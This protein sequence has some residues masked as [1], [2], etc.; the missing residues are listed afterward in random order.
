MVNPLGPGGG[1][2]LGEVP[3]EWQSTTQFEEE[4]PVTVNAPLSPNA[5]LVG[6]SPL[7]GEAI[8]G[9]LL[10]LEMGWQNTES[11]LQLGDVWENYVMVEWRTGTGERLAEQLDPLPLPIE[12]WGRGAVLRSRHDVIVPPILESGRY[13]LWAMLH[14]S[15]DP[16]GEAIKLA[17]IN[18]TAP[19]HNF[20]LPAEAML[21]VGPAQLA[22][23]PWITITL[24]GYALT[25]QDDALNVE[26]YWQTDAPLSASYKLFA[27]LLAPTVHWRPNPTPPRLPD[28]DPPPA[29]CPA[30]S[31]P[32]RT[33]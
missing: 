9:D 15:S 31:S 3:V 12:Q 32:I 8:T 33:P 26:L 11:L 7:P 13:G 19:P 27:Q 21:P 14:T 6:H 20:N 25:R 5:A 10:P 2:L 17:D 22:V 30:K 29:G 28:S 24:A 4:W 18:V 16:A 23:D 1:L